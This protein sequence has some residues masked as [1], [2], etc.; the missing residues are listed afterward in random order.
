M[1]TGT[2]HSDYFQSPPTHCRSEL[3]EMDTVLAG[4]GAWTQWSHSMQSE[5]HYTGVTANNDLSDKAFMSADDWTYPSNISLER[6]QDI[7]TDVS[8]APN[9][10]SILAAVPE[11]SYDDRHPLPEEELAARQLKPTALARLDQPNPMTDAKV[12]RWVPVP[13]GHRFAIP[14]NARNDG[15]ASRR[16]RSIRE[17]GTGSASWVLVPATSHDIDSNTQ[18]LATGIPLPSDASYS[19]WLDA[20]QMYE[21]SYHPSA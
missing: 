4:R 19:T 18:G 5:P 14:S 10:E 13:P 11:F 7:S 16:H 1:S 8:V 17:P 21:E 20:D 12:H 2:T 6:V 3:A 9:T 15:R